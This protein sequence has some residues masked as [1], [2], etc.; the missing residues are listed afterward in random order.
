MCNRYTASQREAIRIYGKDIIPYLVL[1]EWQPIY[2]IPPT[3]RVPV[4]VGESE[5]P[6]RL[7]HWGTQTVKGLVMNAR[8]ET[9]LEK[10]LWK[11]AADKRR[12]VM[13]ADGFFE[14]ETVGRK[15]LG[16]YFTLH[17]HKPF[18]LAGVWF[19]ATDQ[20]PDRVVMVTCE[21]NPLVK[22]FHD[23]M[24]AML[25]VQSAKEWLAVDTLT[26][27]VVSR[28]CQPYPVSEMNHWRSPPEMNSVS[29]QN[30]N[31]LLPWSP[32]PD[33]FS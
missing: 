32:E 5:H 31:A 20:Q 15:K 17:G 23:R 11:G 3:S 9:L 33:L 4:I 1:E 26:S 12:C 29:Y 18:A 7:L 2:N 6:G 13:L 21:P 30:G 27:E 19:P 16:H 28:L 10:S 25:S 22:R 8:S 14:W 24:P